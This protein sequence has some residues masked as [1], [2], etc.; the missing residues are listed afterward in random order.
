M[1]NRVFRTL[2]IAILMDVL[3]SSSSLWADVGA[4]CSERRLSAHS[5]EKLL[6]EVAM[7][8]WFNCSKKLEGRADDG[9]ETS[10]AMLAERGVDASNETI[11]RWFLKFGRLIASN[12]RQSFDRNTYQPFMIRG[13]GQT[14]GL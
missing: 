7:A 12:L 11:R 1:A 9:A 13:S 5:V 3:M 8:A 6:L 2:N 14:I 10:C 4:R